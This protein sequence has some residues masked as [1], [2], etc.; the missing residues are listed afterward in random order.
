MRKIEENRKVVVTSMTDKEVELI[1]QAAKETR[2]SRS[3]FVA[4]HSLDSAE[5]LVNDLKTESE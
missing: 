2:Q 3:Q 5:R 4:K 1:D